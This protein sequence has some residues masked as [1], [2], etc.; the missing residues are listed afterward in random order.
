[1]DRN[2][3]AVLSVAHRNRRL[4]GRSGDAQASDTKGKMY[5]VVYRLSMTS[6]C[7]SLILVLNC[8]SQFWYINCCQ[9][10]FL[11]LRLILRFRYIAVL[12][13]QNVSYSCYQSCDSSFPS[14]LLII[15]DGPPSCS[16]K[17]WS[18]ATPKS[19]WV[20]TV[21]QHPKCCV[22]HWYSICSCGMTSL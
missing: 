20:A 8:C 5:T 4:E 19:L 17:R 21:V 14:S 1:M 16:G 2:S 9:L 7:F 15:W 10:L 6:Y 22:H 3:I 13:D 11:L 18:S 12:L